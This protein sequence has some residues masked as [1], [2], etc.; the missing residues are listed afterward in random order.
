MTRNSA[1]TE[2]VAPT[3]RKKLSLTKNTVRDLQLRGQANEVKAG[4]KSISVQ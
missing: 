2:R 1:K 4:K 3:P